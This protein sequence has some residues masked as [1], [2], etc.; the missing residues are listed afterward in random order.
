VVVRPPGSRS[1]TGRLVGRIH[2]QVVALTAKARERPEE[3]KA[4]LDSFRLD[5][6]KPA[7]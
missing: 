7:R 2:Y 6:N 1:I 4:F 3:M 5:V